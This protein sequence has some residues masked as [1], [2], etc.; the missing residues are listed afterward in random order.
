MNE[1]AS[2]KDILSRHAHFEVGTTLFN[3]D[4]VFK[5]GHPK[6]AYNIEAASG[7][8]KT[9]LLS[10][11][12]A[13]FLDEGLGL[14]T[15]GPWGVVDV[16]K[17][18]SVFLAKYREVVE[19]HTHFIL[20]QV[21][22]HTTLFRT[23]VAQLL[24]MEDIEWMEHLHIKPSL[25]SS[26]DPARQGTAWLMMM[27]LI[28][29]LIEDLCDRVGKDIKP[30]TTADEVKAITDKFCEYPQVMLLDDLDAFLGEDILRDYLRFLREM[31]PNLHVIYT[32]RPRDVL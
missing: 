20:G 14:T 11:L 9:Q 15:F 21:S 16:L 22:E 31:F 26:F 18:S 6:R 27:S 17:Q 10:K 2:M 30:G 19:S 4:H 32:T 24:F 1:K 8:G 12:K 25:S 7:V 29:L 28:F 3:L 23:T 5:Y 13:I